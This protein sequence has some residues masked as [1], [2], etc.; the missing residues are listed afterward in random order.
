MPQLQIETFVSQYFWFLVI[1]GWFYFI[2][3]TDTLVLTNKILK[4]RKFFEG[5]TAAEVDAV[6]FDSSRDVLISKVI[7]NISGVSLKAQGAE[8]E[9]SLSSARKAWLASIKL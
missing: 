6:A 9:N 2:V 4:A 8:I 5:K 1:L 3:A 7:G